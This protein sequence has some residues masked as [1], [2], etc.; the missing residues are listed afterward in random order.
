M[1]GRIFQ[2][3]TKPINK[4]D[5]Y[6]NDY[7]YDNS[8]DF[9]DYIGNEIEDE[10]RERDIKVFADLISDVFTLKGKDVLVFKGTDALNG[11]LKVWVDKIKGAALDLD[12]NNILRLSTLYNI[13]SLTENTHLASYY[14]VALE[15][16]GYASPLAA[17]FINMAESLK[18]GDCLYIGAVI[19]YH[20]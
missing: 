7:F 3:S 5:F 16:D 19:D 2:I 6:T 17:L 10:E 15:D 9:A 11:F 4:E 20:F 8:S 1:H 18:E 14:R 13:R 12:T